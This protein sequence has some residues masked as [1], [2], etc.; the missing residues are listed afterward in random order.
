MPAGWTTAPLRELLT[1]LRT[2]PFGSALHKSD[3]VDGGIPVINPMNLID[4]RIVPT[5]NKAVGDSTAKRLR[6]YA[7]R[8]GDL[9][10]GRRGEMGR[11][12][13]V[14]ESQSG[15]LC[16]T[17]S[18]VLRFRAGFLPPFARYLIS[19]PAARAYLSDAS[20]GTTMENLNQQVLKDWQVPVPPVDEQQRIVA[21]LDA[22]L[23]RVRASKERLA[24]VPTILKRFRQSV[25][26]GACSGWLTAGWRRAWGVEVEAWQQKTLARVCICIT[27]GDHQPPPKQ[28]SGVPFLTIGNISSGKL[29]FSGT[30]FVGEDYYSSISNDRRPRPGDVLYSVVATIGIPI[31]VDTD[32]PFCFQRHIALLRPSNAVHSEFLSCV[33]GSPAVVQ[34]ARER[35]TGTA[36]P[37]LSLGSLRS[38]PISVPTLEE[39]RE[40]VR[41]VQAL[42]AFADRLDARLKNATHQVDQLT[43]SILAKAFRGELVPTEAELAKA[44][45]RTY[46]TAEELL[47][48][49]RSQHPKPVA[50]KLKRKGA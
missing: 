44:E 10:L 14:S 20:V 28:S 40:I 49:I 21:K 25:L 11:C 30:R 2:G 45:G 34:A 5:A 9:V 18:A 43:Q 8:E 13:V 23:A 37:T 15:W 46:E 7:V 41:R 12:A 22:L 1:E 42:F 33:L 27:D 48:R 16:G 50:R 36:Q 32:R 17:G 29:D 31:V 3:Y 19:S 24:T 4:G 26:A 38:L 6:D 35:A 39:Q 47:N